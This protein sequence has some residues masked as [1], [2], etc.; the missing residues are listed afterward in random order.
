M[1]LESFSKIFDLLGF[2]QNELK[3]HIMKGNFQIMPHA[4]K[5]YTHL[6]RF[7]KNTE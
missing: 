7:T 2:V 5:S 1:K 4:V 3:L 6:A